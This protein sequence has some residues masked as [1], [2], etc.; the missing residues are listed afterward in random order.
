[1]NLG[2]ASAFE[3]ARLG[4]KL[5]C[6]LATGCASLQFAAISHGQDRP[7]WGFAAISAKQRNLR[8][9]EITR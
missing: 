2:R 7:I 9:P 6:A 1:M 4:W 3:H 8:L 5:R